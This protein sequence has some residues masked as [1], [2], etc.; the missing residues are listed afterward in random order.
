MLTS[1]ILSGSCSVEA[2]K[3]NNLFAA[4]STMAILSAIVLM[5]CRLMVAC[6]WV[7][8]SPDAGCSTATMLI[9]PSRSHLEEGYAQ[10]FG[11]TSHKATSGHCWH[12]DTRSTR[13]GIN[14][15]NDD[16]FD[17]VTDSVTRLKPRLLPFTR[18]TQFA[19]AQASSARTNPFRGF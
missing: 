3:Q 18:E 5:R 9:G 15:H 14:C 10:V 6:G 12:I 13:R 2:L 16:G 8:Y 19:C 1:Q 7:L 17:M 11:S 4:R